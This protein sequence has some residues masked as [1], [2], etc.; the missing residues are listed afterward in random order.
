[1]RQG[2]SNPID[3]H[4]GARVRA[5]RLV[6]AMTQET[7]GSELGI[8]FQQVQKYEKGTNRISASRLHAIA[9]LLRVPVASFFEA[10]PGGPQTLSRGG[11][12]RTS[13]VLDL[14]STRDGIRLNEAFARIKDTGLRRQLVDL[15]KAI[16]GVDDT[17]D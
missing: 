16:A 2:G 15:V 8:S 17:P 11:R 12:D 6:L 13:A 10:A 3:V 5:R 7:L 4:V 14:L 9:R 1:M